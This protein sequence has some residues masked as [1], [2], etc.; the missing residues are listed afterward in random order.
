MIKIPKVSIDG[1]KWA[2][3]VFT[4]PHCEVQLPE[5]H[6]IYFHAIGIAET[7]Y[8]IMK[9]I[10]CPYCFEKYYSHASDSDIFHIKEF[11][12]K[13]QHLKYLININKNE[14]L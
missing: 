1:A 3:G 11:S 14:K 13:N 9:V 10:E 7:N 4:C 6:H 5:P 2:R 8:G 12:N